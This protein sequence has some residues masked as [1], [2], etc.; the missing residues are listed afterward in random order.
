LAAANEYNSTTTAQGE[1]DEKSALTARQLSDEGT[2]QYK[3]F[4]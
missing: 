1:K 4:Y 2:D 3:R